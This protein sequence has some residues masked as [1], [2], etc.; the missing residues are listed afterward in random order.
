MRHLWRRKDDCGG[1]KLQKRALRYKRRPPQQRID[2]RDDV[3]GSAETR[4]TGP[5][6]RARASARPGGP[7]CSGIDGVATV[8]AAEVGESL[9]AGQPILMVEA[10]GK[11]WLSFNVRKD[12]L[13][14]LSLGETASDCLDR[15][16]ICGHRRYLDESRRN[17]VNNSKDGFVAIL[18]GSDHG[19]VYQ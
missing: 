3:C 13:D 6:R 7:A 9:R 2:I 16:S 1:R 18:S 8:H 4:M 15:R 12:H 10:A 11:L 14:R 19:K 17:G 5:G